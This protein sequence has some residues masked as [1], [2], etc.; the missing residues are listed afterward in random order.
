MDK[1]TTLG[2]YAM[3]NRDELKSLIDSGNTIWDIMSLKSCSRNTVVNYV[4]KFNIKLPKGFY[5]KG[6][7]T[8]RPSGFKHT[9]E[10]KENHRKA[11]SGENNPFFGKEHSKETKEKMSENHADFRGNKNPFKNSLKDPEKKKA[12][13]KRCQ[14]TWDLRDEEWRENFG[15][16][17]SLSISNSKYFENK[18]FHK[19]HKSC[20][21]KTKK[22]G[23]IFC[24]SS[25][26]KEF[27]LYLD[28][29]CLVE[30]FSLEPF[31][32]PYINS[33][34]KKKT[35]RIDFYIILK[36]NK[37]VIVEI[38][39][40]NLLKYNENEF[41]IKGQKVFCKNN[42]IEFLVLGKDEIFK[43]RTCYF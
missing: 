15:K 39:P 30:S 18:K 23:K 33:K 12:H 9:K 38:K 25:W 32:I 43:N 2:G 20:F 4:K 35:T 19:N 11:M 31:C 34:N 22:A 10:W 3:F 8:G 21:L 42:G 36:N 40:K 6:L 1:H 27:A 16:K 29:N 28:E 24:R 14:D 26:E 5:S 37:A 13:K 41:K 7:K 17:L